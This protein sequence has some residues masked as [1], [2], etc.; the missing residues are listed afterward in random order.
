MLLVGLVLLI[1]AATIDVGRR[2]EEI[3]LP[4]TELVIGVVVFALTDL[5]VGR[6]R[7]G[8]ENKE[9]NT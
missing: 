2:V 4:V 1:D 8:H 6:E 5:S 3:L 7:D 9:F